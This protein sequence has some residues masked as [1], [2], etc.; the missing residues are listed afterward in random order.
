[1]DGCNKCC[2][3]NT[4]PL[5]QWML[6]V[7]PWN[8]DSNIDGMDGWNWC[9]QIT[10]YLSIC[11]CLKPRILVSTPP[12]LK[13]YVKFERMCGYNYSFVIEKG[14]FVKWMAATGGELTQYLWNQ[15]RLQVL[16]S[17]KDSTLEN[18]RS[19]Q[20]ASWKNDGTTKCMAASHP[21]K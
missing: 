19:L 7:L 9:H 4:V 14:S 2:E 6:Q 13:K 15:R 5:T 10:G 20:V 21:L 18:T 11:T 3:I 8:N 1:M 17:K 12:V 16:I